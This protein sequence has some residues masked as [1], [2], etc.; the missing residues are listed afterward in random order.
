V[1]NPP[2]AMGR[3]GFPLPQEKLSGLIGLHFRRLLADLK[4]LKQ[5]TVAG[6]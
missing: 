6:R 5:K 4:A 1:E 2:P 3:N